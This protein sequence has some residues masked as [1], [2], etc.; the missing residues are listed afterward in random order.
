M[1]RATSRVPLGPR[2]SSQRAPHS[3]SARTWKRA[4][5]QQRLS[6]AKAKRRRA[7]QLSALS[8]HRSRLLHGSDEERREVLREIVT[9]FAREVLGHFDPRVHAFA[10]KAVPFGLSALLHAAVTGVL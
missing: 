3:A 6:K 9:A 1:A 5:A 2:I 10:T 7:Q 8:R 4:K